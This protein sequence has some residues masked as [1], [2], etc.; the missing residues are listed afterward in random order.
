[1]YQEILA[2]AQSLHFSGIFCEATGIFREATTGAKMSLAS[3]AK[4][5]SLRKSIKILY[6]VISIFREAIISTKMSPGNICIGTAPIAL[7]LP[8]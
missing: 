2:P 8:R 1:M 7:N 4:Q 3:I 5:T 6:E